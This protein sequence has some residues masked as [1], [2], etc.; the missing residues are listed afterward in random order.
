[1]AAQKNATAFGMVLYLWRPNT[2]T[3]NMRVSLSS[4]GSSWDVANQDDTLMASN[5]TAGAWHHIAAVYDVAAGKHY[6]YYDGVKQK[7]YT[8]ANICVVD[9]FLAGADL[10]VGLL[11]TGGY[12]DEY[13]VLKSCTYPGGTTFTPPGTPF[14]N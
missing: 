1:M 5:I 9:S 3:C 10:T 13:R 7:E 2:T 12:I 6:F 14:E 8:A 11:G 4:N